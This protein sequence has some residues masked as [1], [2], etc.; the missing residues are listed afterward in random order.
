MAHTLDRIDTAGDYAPGNVRWADWSTQRTNQARTKFF[1]HPTHGP[2]TL[3]RWTEL[4]GVNYRAVYYRV[5]TLGQ[6][7]LDAVEHFKSRHG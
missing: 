6:P 2:I 1:A 4:E 7:L 5:H 3:K